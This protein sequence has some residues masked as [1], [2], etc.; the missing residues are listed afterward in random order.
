MPMIDVYATTGTFADKHQL[1]VDLAT[2]VMFI[3]GVPDIATD[4]LSNVNGDNTY[5]HVEVLTNAGALDRDKQLAVVDQLTQI[6]AAA[7]GD[8]TLPSGPGCCSPNP[9]KAAGASRATPTPTTDSS[10]Q[11]ARR[12]PSC[13]PVP[14]GGQ[15]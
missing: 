2:T 14:D 11:P 1:A 4:N 9:S 15:R 3:E 10:T 8:S 13:G 6:V 12:S 7:A 5:V